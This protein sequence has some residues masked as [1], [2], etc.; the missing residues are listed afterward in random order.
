MTSFE[1]KVVPAPQRGQ[2]SRGVKGTEA[3]FALALERVMNEMAEGGWEYQRTDTLPVEERQGLNGTTTS[4]KT[5]LI[6]RR[7]RPESV[8]AF[9]PRQIE[10]P[11]PAPALPP[12]ASAPTAEKP[13]KPRRSAFSVVDKPSEPAPAPEP[14]ATAPAPEP[15]AS[16]GPALLA[17]ARQL[18]TRD[19]PDVA[20]E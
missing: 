19:K 16:P 20:A 5:M 2:K 11:A 4:Y 14:A 1:Y 18:A 8:A 3:R 9:Q 15:S 6:F 13:I 17:R 12:A 10:S 7:A